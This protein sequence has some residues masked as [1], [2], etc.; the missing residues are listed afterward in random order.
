[1]RGD[2]SD[3]V[4][5]ELVGEEMEGAKSL[6]GSLLQWLGQTGQMRGLLYKK[7]IAGVESHQRGKKVIVPERCARSC[8]AAAHGVHFEGVAMRG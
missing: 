6:I 2:R 8:W 4:C 7:D 1:M 3:Q 5:C